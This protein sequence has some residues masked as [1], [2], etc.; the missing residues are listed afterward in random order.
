MAD[1]TCR[2]LAGGSLGND[3]EAKRDFTRTDDDEEGGLQLHYLNG[4]ECMYDPN[5]KSSLIID[6]YCTDDKTAPPTF[7]SFE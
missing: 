7:T 2:P 1:G 5:K 4:A 6:L 3:V